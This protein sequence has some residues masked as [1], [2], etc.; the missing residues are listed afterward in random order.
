LEQFGEREE[1]LAMARMVGYGW[2]AGKSKQICYWTP[3]GNI[4]ELSVP[5]GGTWQVAALT[6]D[7]NAPLAGDGEITGY[8][9]PTVGSKQ[10]CF[11]TDN[12]HIHEMYK[13]TSYGWHHADLTALAAAPPAAERTMTGYSWGKGGSKQIAYKGS[14]GHI[15]ELYVVSGGKW[16]HADLTILTGA[17]P[18][19]YGALSGYEWETVGTKQ[20][21]YKDANGHIHELWVGVGGSWK[22]ADLTKIASA[23]PASG[24]FLTGY[25]WEKGGSKQVVYTTNDGHIHELWVRPD[26]EWK[27]ADLMQM[28]GAPTAIGTGTSVAAY[29]WPTQGTKQVAYVGSGGQGMLE[30]YVGVSGPWKH[31]NLTQ[32]A[33]GPAPDLSGYFTGYS[34]EAGKSKQ[35][36]YTTSDG[37]FH[38]LFV[39]QGGSWTHAQL[40]GQQH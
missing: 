39:I 3:N 37:H 29:E 14:N 19:G 28:T 7:S 15:H 31:A 22:H 10:V 30:L 38:E 4:G 40:P 16:K 5:V 23:P 20:V 11:F 8:S 12:N 9:W 1:E 27:H 35:V 26:E 32:I 2:E 33:G 34:W 36:A 17:P 18:Y 13:G 24:G 25:E 6:A 21:V